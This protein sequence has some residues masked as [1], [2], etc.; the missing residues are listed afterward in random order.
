[1]RAQFDEARASYEAAMARV[2][3][4]QALLDK[5][6]VEA[7]FSGVLGLREVDLGEF[8]AVGT[9]IVEINMLDPIQVDFTIAEAQLPLIAVGDRVEVSVSAWP[10]R[11]FSGRVLALESSV[12]AATRT[13][14]VRASLDNSEQR[15]RPGMFAEVRTY[16]D[17]VREVVTVPRTAVSY[18]TYGDFVFVI[19][20]DGGSKTVQRR[21]VTTGEVRD[22]QVEVVDGLEAGTPVVAAG[23]LRLR[24]GQAVR[25]TA[26]SGDA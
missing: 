13:V 11:V 19:A 3:E 24:G 22:G 18:N 9:P 17:R 10:E 25:V 8:L 20:D 4:Q 12:T 7:P 1:S 14:R 23:L 6:T 15:L 26:E 5:K 21:S 16:Q 2:H